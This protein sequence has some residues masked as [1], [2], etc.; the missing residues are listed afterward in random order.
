MDMP[1]FSLGL[2]QE[3]A[4]NGNHGITF[5]ESVRHQ[6]ESIVKAVDNI[7]VRH[8]YRKSKRQKCVPHALLADYECGPEIGSRVKK[9][10]NFIFSSH[11]RNQID[12]KYERLL[13]RV[14]RHL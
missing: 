1:S 11:E 12:R 2:T 5:K 6:P 3:E 4:L 10:Q 14:N 7:E 13:Q 9:S 8:Q